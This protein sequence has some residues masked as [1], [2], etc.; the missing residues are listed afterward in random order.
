MTNLPGADLHWPEGC[1][2]GTAMHELSLLENVR[3]ILENHAVSQ[4]FSKVS[5]VTLE[6]GKL[7][8][9]EPDA[10][11]FGFDVVMKDSL[12]E[13]AEL[14]ISDI[15]GLGICQQCGLEVELE[16]SHDPCS[17]CGSPR[18]KIVQGADMKI[19]DLIVI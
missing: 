6:I 16:T 12:A 17:Y 10:L 9:V 5:Q 11:R 7:S 4:K 13:N 14:I 19:K 8:S 1:M 15:A 3:E 18:V 2:A